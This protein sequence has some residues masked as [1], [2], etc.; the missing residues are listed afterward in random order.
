M[1][2]HP[3]QL[4]R[5]GRTEPKRQTTVTV[6][7]SPTDDH[8]TTTIRPASADG[9]DL[10]RTGLYRRC[11][12]GRAPAG[13]GQLGKRADLAAGSAGCRRIDVAPDARAGH[14][15]GRSA[16]GR[17][18]QRSRLSPGRQL[19]QAERSLRVFCGQGF[20][21]QCVRRTR[22]LH[23]SEFRAAD[24]YPERKR[25]GRRDRAR[26][27]P[28]HAEPPATCVRGFQERCAVDGTG[29]AGRH[30]RE[31]RQPQRRCADRDTGRRPG[32]ARAEVD[33]LH[34]QG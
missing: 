4:K 17:L 10:R 31:C 14:G 28:Y 2:P 18:H 24:D 27:R 15:G 12:A 8:D 9:P 30:C 21:N 26:D 5:P 16:A 6:L 3:H 29:A 7:L 13:P 33:Q 19:R 11:A 23:R 22:R 34:P 25:A 32:F 20:G 1:G